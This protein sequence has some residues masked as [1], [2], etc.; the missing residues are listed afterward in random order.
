MVILGFVLMAIF[1]A[2]V[3]FSL[4]TW[5]YRKSGITVWRPEM[6][7]PFNWVFMP[8]LLTETGLKYRKAALFAWASYIGILVLSFILDA[9]GLLSN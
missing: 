4:L 7:N 5:S 6:T 9:F 2:V 1:F 8:E 3:L